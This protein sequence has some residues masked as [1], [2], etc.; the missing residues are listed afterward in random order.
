MAA[1]LSHKVSLIAGLSAFIA[2]LYAIA[3]VPAEAAQLER[4]AGENETCRIPYPT[5]VIYGAD[6]RGTSQFI[7]RPN[8]RCSN[9]VFGDPAPGRR[10][11]CSFV[12]RERFEDRRDDRGRGEWQRCANENGYCDFYGRKV[13]RYGAK[14]RFVERVFRNGAPCDNRTFGDP[15]RGKGKACYI[16]N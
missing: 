7:D 2:S 10:K 5:E 9:Q 3:P 6:G 16:Q 12:V 15:A 13:V 8:V 14:G 1:Y 4:C 11:S